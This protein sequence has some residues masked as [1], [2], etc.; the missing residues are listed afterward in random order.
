MQDH[1]DN[2]PTKK[3]R[4]P[5]AITQEKIDF[6]TFKPIDKKKIEL[7]MKSNDA[8]VEFLPLSRDY[9]LS[10]LF[11][12]FFDDEFLD[13]L[14][15]YNSSK[16]ERLPSLFAKQNNSR[17]YPDIQQSK[18]DL[19]IRFYAIK[20]FILSNPEAT[21]VDNFKTGTSL[22]VPGYED[23]SMSYEMFEKMNVNFIIPISLV[24]TFNARL[25]QFLSHT[26]RI[27]CFDEK[28][29][30]CQENHN[31]AR[32]AKGKQGHWISECSILGPKTGLPYM[33]RV[34]PTTTVDNRNVEDEPYNNKLV[35][36]LVE[37]AYTNVHDESILVAD[38][39]YPDIAGR[40]YCKKNEKL[41]LF[42]VSKKR[43]PELFATAEKAI[44]IND[45]DD[46]VVLHSEETQEHF[47]FY[48]SYQGKKVKK[49]RNI[50][51]RIHQHQCSK[52][53]PRAEYN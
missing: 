27:V 6:S 16:A 35:S 30:N 8:K 34:M 4:N 49:K 5:E 26:G 12:S 1:V 28:H 51:Q 31:H 11:F 38:G 48:I 24:G 29:K 47:M 19:V 25:D 41:Y 7:K 32:W 3:K 14:I 18:R 23:F 40:K 33:L 2:T 39:Y 21:L 46:F 9:S 44:D 37:D 15:E 22:E 17:A 52:E 10:S 42:K 50:D 36:E 43:F 20:L 53:I 13:E 45:R